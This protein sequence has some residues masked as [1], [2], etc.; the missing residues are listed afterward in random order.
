MNREVSVR[1]ITS[2][3]DCSNGESKNYLLVLFNGNNDEHYGSEI[4][5]NKTFDG[6]VIRNVNMM[7][8]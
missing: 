7:N 4:V 1:V 5:K 3:F 6:V 2:V 8:T